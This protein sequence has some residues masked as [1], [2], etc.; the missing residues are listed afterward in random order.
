MVRITRHIWDQSRPDLRRFVFFGSSSADEWWA[1][2]VE[3]PTEI[4]VYTPRMGGEYEVVGTDV[5]DVW[6]EDYA[7]YG[8]VE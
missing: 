1:L 7:L 4:I 2:H 3:R 6:R 5:I 8:E